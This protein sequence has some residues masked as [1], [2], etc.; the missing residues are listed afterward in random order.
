MGCQLGVPCRELDRHVP[1]SCARL[2]CSIVDLRAAMSLR[3]WNRSSMPLSSLRRPMSFAALGIAV[4]V[5][6]C[7]ESTAPLF[8]PHTSQYQ[9]GTGT[10]IVS[11]A[12]MRGW[13]F[14]NDQADAPCT[15][16]SVCRLVQGPG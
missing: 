9:N 13:A 12:N 4:A 2:P 15:D 16:T 7:R 3:F 10:V 6:A 1:G 5:L 8:A 11:P 14:Y